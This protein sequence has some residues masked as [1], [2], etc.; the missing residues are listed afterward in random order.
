MADDKTSLGGTRRELK[1]TLWANVGCDMVDICSLGFAVAS[2]HI[3]RLPGA[4]LAGGAAVCAGLGLLGL[5]G[6]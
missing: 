2:G 5:N 3:G 4:L 6:I 1:R